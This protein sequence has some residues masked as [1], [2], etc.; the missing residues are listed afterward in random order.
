MTRAR[1]ILALLLVWA[2]YWAALPWIDCMRANPFGIDVTFTR[3]CTFGAGSIS[4][5]AARLGAR[6]GL[7]P[8]ILVGLV[9]LVAAFIVARRRPS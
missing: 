2:A 7:W 6:P 1:L 5:D 4:A 8:D 3:L 9:Y